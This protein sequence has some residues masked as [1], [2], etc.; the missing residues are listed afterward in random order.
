MVFRGDTGTYIRY[1][2]DENIS[3]AS[4]LMFYYA[5]PSGETGSWTAT[6]YGTDAVQYQTVSG[7]LDEAGTWRL[8]PHITTPMWS[9]Y[10][11]IVELEVLP[12]LV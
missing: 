12:T 3:D 4:A 2:V 9:G 1:T 11:E 7:D 10:G 8:Q 6:L 5:T